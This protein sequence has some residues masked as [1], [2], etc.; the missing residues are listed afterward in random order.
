MLKFVYLRSLINRAIALSLNSTVLPHFLQTNCM[1]AMFDVM[2]SYSIAAR[3]RCR[4]ITC[5]I[6]AATN[7]LSA[8]YTVPTEIRCSLHASINWLAVNG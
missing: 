1:C 3:P 2:I 8:L 4:S 5:K 7:K 6:C